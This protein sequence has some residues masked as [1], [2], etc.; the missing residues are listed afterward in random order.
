MS[1]PKNSNSLYYNKVRVIIYISISLIFT[2]ASFHLNLNQDSYSGRYSSILFIIAPLSIILALFSTFFYLFLLFS[3]RALVKIT[4]K[5]F[6]INQLF[7]Y[8]SINWSE[9]VVI[10]KYQIT[11]PNPGSYGITTI[12]NKYVQIL[13]IKGKKYQISPVATG[14]NVD[15]LLDWIKQTCLKYP[16]LQNIN[17]SD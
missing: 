6:I 14:K 11:I 4:D 5:E 15:Q 12:K 8:K 2:V 1:I 9:I 16:N 10:S 3:N 7:K 13:D 17:F